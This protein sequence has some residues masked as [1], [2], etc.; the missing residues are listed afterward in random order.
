MQFGQMQQTIS[1]RH[2]LLVTLL[3][4]NESLE[5]L[6]VCLTKESEKMKELHEDIYNM[7]VFGGM[8]ISQ[9]AVEVGL[10]TDEVTNVVVFMSSLI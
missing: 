5:E 3:R 4:V 9:I 7:F 6:T 2:L 10:T 8:T 1:L